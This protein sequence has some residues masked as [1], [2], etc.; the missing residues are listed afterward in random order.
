M[1]SAV[2]LQQSARATLARRQRAGFILAALIVAGYIVLIDAMAFAPDVLA[3][4]AWRGS[5]IT[6]GLAGAMLYSLLVLA[7]SGSYVW[8]RNQLESISAAATG[9][10]S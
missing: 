4:P 1:A 5:I 2:D 7:A 9:A 10:A 6:R 3:H 8:W